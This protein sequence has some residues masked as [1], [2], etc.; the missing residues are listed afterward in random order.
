MYTRRGGE[1]PAGRYLAIL[2]VRLWPMA[3]RIALRLA[4]HERSEITPVRAPVLIL[5][6][7]GT[8][9]MT[10][11]ADGWQPA[12][13]FD[14]HIRAAQ[15]ARCQT[16]MP[17]WTYLA[18]EPPIDS[19]N[20]TQP[21]WLAMRDVIVQ[22]VARRQ[23]GGVLILHGTDTLAY[24]AAALS[25]LLLGLPVPVC[26]TGSMIPASA[27]STDAWGNLFDAL[28]WLSAAPPGGVHV[29]F[30]GKRLPGVWVTKRFS[31]R[32]DAFV[33]MRP[34]VK[35]ALNKS[36]GQAGAADR[37]GLQGANRSRSLCYDEDLQRGRARALIQSIPKGGAGNAAAATRAS[38][39]LH[40]VDY[41]V[42]R[43]PVPLGVQP[44]Y[45]GMDAAVFDGL[46]A[47]GVRGVVLELYGSGTGP[48]DD[49]RFLAALQRARQDGVVVVGISQCPS[50][51][52][53]GAQYAAAS[54]LVQ[55]GVL[56]GG[57]MTREAAL[58]K[59]FGLLGAGLSADHVRQ[60]WRRDLCGE[61]GRAGS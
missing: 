15:T 30:D 47:T 55:T 46:L 53:E 19:A 37:D 39:D 44:L 61:W 40:P 33:V 48:T 57:A 45:P 10:L 13:G 52:V 21:H 49:A 3:R 51:Q 59:L 24:T 43:I 4:V 56:P 26:V 23:C 17:P 31:D 20:M 42:A 2:C 11:G 6:T 7:G 16:P 29:A 5:Y 34:T 14:A 9:G 1:P 41:T 38:V 28:Q 36:S 25:F 54:R 22:A 60:W 27:P 32:P 35:D 18:V 8:I 12:S 50:G 58:G